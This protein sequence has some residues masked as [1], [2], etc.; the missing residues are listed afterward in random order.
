MILANE[1]LILSI[2]AFIVAFIAA[3]SILLCPLLY[4]TTELIYTVDSSTCWLSSSSY[5]Y[6]YLDPL[7][8]WVWPVAPPFTTKYYYFSFG[9]TE[10]SFFI[11]LSI[12]SRMLLALSTFFFS[13]SF[14]LL[15]CRFSICD[16]LAYICCCI[17]WLSL[18]NLSSKSFCLLLY[19]SSIIFLCWSYLSWTSFFKS[20][21]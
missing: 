8:L 6:L 17:S 5:W 11:S 19:S 4:G 16:F 15:F 10:V 9:A 12:S 20:C 1:L 18:A 2:S 14:I 7:L 21:C 13:T 3:S